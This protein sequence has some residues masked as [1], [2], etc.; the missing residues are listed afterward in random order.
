MGYNTIEALQGFLGSQKN[1]GKIANE[2]GQGG[3]KPK[4]QGAEETI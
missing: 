2:L 4:E 1:G 3:K